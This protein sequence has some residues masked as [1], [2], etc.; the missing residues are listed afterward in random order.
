MIHVNRI[1]EYLDN[2]P[3]DHNRHS[4]VSPTAPPAQKL[5]QMVRT[6]ESQVS[7]NPRVA[8]GI[9]LSLGMIIGWI[10]KRR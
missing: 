10:V 8:I 2:P 4:G 1:W 6:V 3:Y 7:N 5:E 9:A